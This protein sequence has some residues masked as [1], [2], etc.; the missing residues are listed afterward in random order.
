[1]PQS[2][3]LS[4]PLDEGGLGTKVRRPVAA[5][6]ILMKLDPLSITRIFILCVHRKVGNLRYHEE[7]LVKQGFESYYPISPP[8]P[9]APWH[10]GFAMFWSHRPIPE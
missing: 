2:S 3:P 5:L 4:S 7:S 8:K 1:M 6:C 9:S 10:H